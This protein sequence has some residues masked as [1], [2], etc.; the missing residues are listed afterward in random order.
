MKI[1]NLKTFLAL[2]EGTIYC[3]YNQSS[4]G[5]L[6][7]KYDSSSFGD[8][9]VYAAVMDIDSESGE[10]LWDKLDLAEKEGIAFPLDFEQTGRDG[11]FDPDQLFAVWEK[12]D[13][14]NFIGK[15]NVCLESYP[16]TIE[17]K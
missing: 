7:I 15:L 12:T 3:K 13:V 14:V 10:D 4:F 6:C 2:P 5:D 17:A 16:E 8:D 1:V 11:L 9:F